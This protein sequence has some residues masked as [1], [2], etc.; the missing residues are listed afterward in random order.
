MSLKKIFIS[1]FIILTGF[2]SV[3]GCDICGCGAGGGFLGVLPQFQKNLIGYRYF[4]NRFLHPQTA[5]NQTDGVF[6]LS[7]T[8]HINDLWM[9]YYATDKLQLFAFVPYRVHYRKYEDNSMQQISGVGDIQINL[10]QEI[11]NQA[12]DADRL[13]RHIWFAGGGLRMPTGLYMQ[14][15]PKGRMYPLPFQTGIGAWAFQFQNL[16]ILR[17]RNLGIQSDVLYRYAMINEL[18]YKLGDFF[19][20]G[21]NVF[22]WWQVSP[23]LALLPLVGYQYETSGQD[24]EFGRPKTNT[25]GAFGFGSAGVDVY[26]KRAIFQFFTQLP[27][28]SSVAGSQPGVG[29]RVGAGVAY[30]W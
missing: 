6:L 11:L 3:F 14:R 26:Y 5:L 28:H 21:G 8:Y 15:D 19:Q 18:E 16:Y 25:G 23:N 24:T 27:I 30:F 7:D 12:A 10:L 9:R 29:T 1:I 20:T 4:Q 17:F 22:Y 2:T 13:F